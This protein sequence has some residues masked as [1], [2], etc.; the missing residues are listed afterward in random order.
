MMGG[1]VTTQ[2]TNEL[3]KELSKGRSFEGATAALSKVTTAAGGDGE[4]QVIKLLE[5]QNTILDKRL[6]GVS[7]G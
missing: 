3:F 2:S 5:T 1:V 6:G 4:A 7:E